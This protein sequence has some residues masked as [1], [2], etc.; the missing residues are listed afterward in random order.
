MMCLC[1]QKPE[2]GAEGKKKTMDSNYPFGEKSEG[3]L[4]FYFIHMHIVGIFQHIPIVIFKKEEHSTR[5]TPWASS[6]NRAK[7]QWPV[8][9]VAW[10]GW[11]VLQ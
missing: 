5:L 6:K 10:L 1:V 2:E 9:G 8:M 4:I 11:E 3:V 7:E